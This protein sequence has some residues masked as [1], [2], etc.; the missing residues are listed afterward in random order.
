MRILITVIVVFGLVPVAQA[1]EWFIFANDGQDQDQQ[2]MD[3]F[4]CI[5]IARDLTD[6]DP[7]ATPTAETSAPQ[8][9]GGAG[10]G[11]AR[12]AA[13]GAAVGAV[14]GNA[15]RGARRGAAGGGVMGGMRRADSN[16]Q[17]QQWAREE[18]ANYQA[19]RDNWTRAFSACMESRGYTVG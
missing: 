5:R 17:Q 15:G 12:G 9:Q 1:Q 16:A 7:M 2:D 6:F 3:E 11:A 8:T 13:L 18:A 19:N 10:R 14:G 4:Q